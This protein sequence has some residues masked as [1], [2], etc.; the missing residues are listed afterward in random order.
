MTK[1]KN[2][3]E[4]KNYM[5]MEKKKS[6]KKR[7][8]KN[9]KRKKKK[10]KNKKKKNMKKKGNGC[11]WRNYIISHSCSIQPGSPVHTFLCHCL[12]FSPSVDVP[13][14]NYSRNFSSFLNY[15]SNNLR[16]NPESVQRESL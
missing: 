12:L 7:R 16:I 4:D 1:T 14:K 9:K 6:R 5:T 2:S 8:N 11:T 13:V 10:T 15:I 3:N